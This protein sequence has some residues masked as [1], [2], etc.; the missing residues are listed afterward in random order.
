MPKKDK[1]KDKSAGSRPADEEKDLEGSEPGE[2]ENTADSPREKSNEESSK[3][4]SSELLM[5]QFEKATASLLAKL[6]QLA[7]AN[8]GA[9]TSKSLS[10]RPSSGKG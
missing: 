10:S 1:D 9:S 2:V 3:V 7:D 5:S 6:K 4:S 8:E